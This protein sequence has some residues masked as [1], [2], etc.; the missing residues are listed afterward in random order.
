MSNQ[1]EAPPCGLE[2]QP[3]PAPRS[4]WLALAVVS[5]G[6]FLAVVSTTVVSVALPTVGRDLHA[7]DTGLEWVVDSY[8]LVYA[9]LLV[10]GGSLGDRHGRKGLFLLGLAIFGCGSLVTGLAPTIGLLLAGRV[11]QGLGPALLVPGSLTIIRAVFDNP[12]QRAAAIGIWS[13][14]SGVALAVGPPLGGVLVTGLGW[15]SVFLLNPPLAAVLLAAGARFLPRLPRTGP[16]STFDWP[17]VVLTTV[18]IA[19]L[20]LGVIEGQ[21]RG[22]TSGWVLA[23]FAAGAAALAG[24]TAA[25]LRRRDPLIDVRIFRQLPFTVVNVTSAVVFFAFVGAIVYF[26]AF[27]QQVQGHSPI[28]AGLDV[29]AVGIAWA[30]TAP[31]S[32]RLVARTGERWPLMIGLLV[33]GAATLGL[34]RLQA[35][36]PLSAIWWNFALLGAGVG[37][38]GTPSSSIAMSAVTAARAGMA[39]AVN[40]ASRQIGQ[41]FGVAVLGALVYA[42][43][44]GGSGTGGRLDAGRQAAFVTGLHHALWMSGLALL[45]AGA[46]TGLLFTRRAAAP[47]PR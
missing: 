36:T 41:V 1:A 40:N 26:S 37:I 3:A 16:R 14:S 13:T 45:A 15:R 10:A 9:S 7:G 39:S 27:F 17:A 25:E 22:W 30:I 34:L 33:S 21:D 2:T 47:A 19:L 4:S 6:L 44:P 18:G 20:A 31:L 43:L 29:A 12:R 23:A 35:A 38:C 5:L 24:F 42:R 46:L 11:L 8:V 32:G 28:A